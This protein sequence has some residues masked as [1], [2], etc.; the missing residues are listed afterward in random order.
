MTVSAIADIRLKKGMAAFVKSN[1]SLD[2]IYKSRISLE[3]N[4]NLTMANP[5]NRPGHRAT[6]LPDWGPTLK[7]MVSAF[8][9]HPHHLLPEIQL[10]AVKNNFKRR[11][12]KWKL[13]LHFF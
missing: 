5:T 11:I 3:K 8:F 12:I 4:S 2:K 10:G 1:Y 7:K 9:K 6:D 13:I